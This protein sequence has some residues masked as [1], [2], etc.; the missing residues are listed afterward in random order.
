MRILSL[1]GGGVRGLIPSIILHRLEQITGK[2]PT[3]LFDLIV[4]TST[5]AM[6]ACVLTV[7]TPSDPKK[8]KYG[9]E[10]LIDVYL[11]ESKF[12]FENSMWK[13]LTTIYGIYGPRYYTK[14]RDDKFNEWIGE[15]RL[16]DTVVDV[17]IPSYDMTTREPYIFKTRKAQRDPEKEDFLM[18]DVVKAATS[19]PTI[20]PPHLINGHLY[21]DALHA[22]NPTM[23]ALVEALT[24]YDAK[25][26][27]VFILS[28]GT[29]YSSNEYQDHKKIIQSGPAFLVEVVNSIINSN[30]VGT[31]YMVNK[32]LPNK[33]QCLYLD[34]ELDDANMGITDISQANLDLIEKKATDFINENED[35]LFSF[36]QKLDPSLT[37]KKEYKNDTSLT[38]KKDTN[39][40]TNNP[41]TKQP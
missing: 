10:R 33:D 31:T 19:A 18:T 12:T 37:T 26:E 23:I 20:F 36:A 32:L 25:P 15:T 7:P 17:L 13:N 40:D 34:I 8:P 39:V 11:K 24:H 27:D 28:I 4:G 2:H 38:T 35:V 16:K 3:E 9:T 29:G 21:L 5:G 30:T 6:I 1:T 22:K 14:N 41:T